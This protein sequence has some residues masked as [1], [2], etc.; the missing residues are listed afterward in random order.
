MRNDGLNEALI[1][2]YLLGDLPEEEQVEIEDRAF[3]D[4]QQVL[5]IQAVEDDLIDEYLRGGLSDVE[6]RQFE[7]RF[8]ASAERRRKVEF[9]RTFAAVVPEFSVSEKA[10]SRIPKTDVT[11]RTALVLLARGLTPAAR[12]AMAA[13]A[14]GLL[15][16][17]SWLA[18]ETFRLRAQLR[19]DMQARQNQEQTLQQQLADERARSDSLAA[20]LQSEQQQREQTDQLL[21]QLE[22]EKELKPEPSQPSIIS[23]ALLPGIPRGS[24]ARP[25]LTLQQS[26]RLVRLQIGIEPGDDYPNFRAEIATNE[27]RRIWTQDKLAP[28]TTGIGRTVVVSLPARILDAGQYELALRGTTA[29]GTIEVI[30]YHYFEVVKK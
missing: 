27:G 2:R 17:G 22:H 11:W 26:A 5:H 16:V 19:S 24:N 8:F 29:E 12:F 6:R 10:R 18:R 9:A 13:G 4:Q 7:T 3:R 1:V 28:R 25:K 15:V 23:L 30:G 20:R 21:S 14:I